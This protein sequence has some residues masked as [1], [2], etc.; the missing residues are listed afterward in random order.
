VPFSPLDIEAALA[1]VC[2]FRATV[3]GW[4]CDVLA[5]VEVLRE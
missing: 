5:D 2:R 1:V 4:R 3:D